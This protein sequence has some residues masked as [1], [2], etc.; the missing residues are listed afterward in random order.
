MS[1]ALCPKPAPGLIDP[2]NSA[3]P[4]THDVVAS[5]LDP[6]DE[7]TVLDFGAGLGNFTA[8]LEGAGYPVPAV[9]IDENDYRRAGHSSAPFLQANL[10]DA[11]PELPGPVGGAVAIEVIEHLENPLG[12]IRAV[13]EVLVDDGWLIVTTPNGLSLS[14]RLEL[15]VRGHDFGFSDEDYRANGHICPVS[16]KQ[17]HRI[18]ARVGLSIAAVTY[19]AGRIPLP[20][21]CKRFVLRS[22]WARSGLLGESLIVKVPQ[23]CRHRGAV[24]ARLAGTDRLMAFARRGPGSPGF[25]RGGPQRT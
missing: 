8:Y 11:L 7:L 12:F 5:L 18:G 24:H 16:L 14:S 3:A 20:R 1:C 22:D 2:T 10:D 21:L 17:L 23:A 9:D 25:G 13:T 19:N 15:M 6:P 4:C